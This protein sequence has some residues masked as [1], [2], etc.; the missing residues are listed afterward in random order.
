MN[1]DD[2]QLREATARAASVLPAALAAVAVRELQT[3][4]DSRTL[5]E[6]DFQLAAEILGMRTAV[7]ITSTSE[8]MQGE[9]GQQVRG[10]GLHGE[11]EHDVRPHE[12]VRGARPDSAAARGRTGP[13]TGN[14]GVAG[15]E[16][17]TVT[18]RDRAAES[19]WGSGP[20]NPVTR[21]V[22]ISAYCPKCGARRGEPQGLNTSDD[23]AFYWVEMWTNPC[24]HADLYAAVVK[25]A[26]ELVDVAELIDTDDDA[27]R[28]PA[29]A[30]ALTPGGKTCQCGNPELSGL[31]HRYAYEG[32]CDGSPVASAWRRPGGRR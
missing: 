27:G 21:T 23:G 4:I 30:P 24:G 32:N 19:P 25:E 5:L 11:R 31:N 20:T 28:K 14:P 26:A 12:D 6:K 8:G 22:T 13:L 17:I 7:T 1:D 29:D 16:T 3:A 18:V 9:R 15:T 10:S 2:T